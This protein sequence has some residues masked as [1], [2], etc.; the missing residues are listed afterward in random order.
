MCDSISVAW[1]MQVKENCL[2][3]VHILFMMFQ[4]MKL[5]LCQSLM[6]NEQLYSGFI[7]SVLPH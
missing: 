1:F 5:E 2:L 6:K 3:H 7:L 4:L